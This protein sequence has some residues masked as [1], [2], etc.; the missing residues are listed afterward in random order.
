V[1]AALARRIRV[2]ARLPPQEEGYDFTT[3]TTPL[4]R[5]YLKDGGLSRPA[6]TDPLRLS[7]LKVVAKTAI[8]SK[9]A[10]PSAR[11]VAPGSK[12]TNK[13]YHSRAGP[14]PASTP[15]KAHQPRPRYGAGKAP[16]TAKLHRST[17]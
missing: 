9:I 2:L 3:W 11:I 7:V 10:K 8:A 16:K 14:S 1:V 17:A 12:N 4:L 13:T 5:T 6:K 15:P